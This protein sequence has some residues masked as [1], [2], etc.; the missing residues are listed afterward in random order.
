[1]SERIS[2]LFTELKAT[3]KTALIP[4][5]TAGYP[6]QQATIPLLHALVDNGADL[7]EVGVPFSDP[8]ADGPVIQQSSFEAIQQGMTVNKVFSLVT[9][10]RKKNQHTPIVLMGYANPIEA[11]GWQAYVEK[12]K[13]CGIDGLLTV[14]LPLETD[15][16]WGNL[17]AEYDLSRIIL[18]SPTTSL[19]R[20]ATLVKYASGFIYYVALKGVT[21]SGKLQAEEDNVISALNA[22]KDLTNTPVVVGFGIKDTDSA[23]K[24]SKS[25]DGVVIG[26]QIIHILSENCHDVEQGILQVGQFMA[27]L[28][29]AIDK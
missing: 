17:C 4:F 10:F 16:S 6:N 14:D 7:I 18:L 12:A 11:F 19:Q 24:L 22:I 2:G 1:M 23:K 21:G 3:Q 26:S 5:I 20:Q 13:Q 9:E 29:Q 15:D 25:A 28:K 27:E 8:V